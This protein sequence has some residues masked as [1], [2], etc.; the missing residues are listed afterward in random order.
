MLK[1]VPIVDIRFSQTGNLVV[2]FPNGECRDSAATLIQ[3]NVGGAVTKK[4]KKLLPKIMICNVHEEEDDVME[5]VI[6]KNV[7]LQSISNVSQKMTFLFK[8]LAASHTAH[9][10]IKCDPEVRRVIH[11]HDDRILLHWGRYQIRDR[12]HVLTCF[13]CQ[14]HGHVSK[15]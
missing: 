14:R 12:Y 11:D 3:G 6:E 15:N 10:I 5:A 8:K 1:N 9:Y 7:Y 2:S 4:V 13:H